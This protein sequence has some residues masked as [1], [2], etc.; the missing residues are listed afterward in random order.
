MT[1]NYPLGG[2]GLYGAPTFSQRTETGTNSPTAVYSYTYNGVTRPDDTVLYGATQLKNSAGGILSSIDYTFTT[3][4]SGSTAVQSI[5]TTDETG[6]QTKVDFDYDQY[7][8][9]VNKREYGYKVSGV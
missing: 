2:E 3:D 9:V 6:Q 1:F 8:N 4:P 5:I 7:G